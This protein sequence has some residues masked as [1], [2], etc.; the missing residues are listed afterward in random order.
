MYVDPLPTRG[1]SLR[2]LGER[3]A[4]ASH[5][6]CA[7]TCQESTAP[8]NA[9]RRGHALRHKGIKLRKVDHGA[10]SGDLN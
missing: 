2:C 1:L 8:H 9:G 4:G 3:R 6:R 5:G 10:S 7:Q